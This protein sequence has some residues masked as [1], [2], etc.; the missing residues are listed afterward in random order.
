MQLHNLIHPQY[1]GPCV[2]G[3]RTAL[4][5][6][7]QRSC[8]WPPYC[9]PDLCN[10]LPHLGPLSRS[11]THQP[12]IPARLDRQIT[13]SEIGTDPDGQTVYVTSLR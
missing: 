13:P 2:I 3:T 8:M 9:H 11:M 1:A 5:G 6:E 4:A 7:R 12:A 10:T